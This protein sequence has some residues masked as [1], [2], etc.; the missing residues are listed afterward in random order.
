MTGHP[1][2]GPGEGHPVPRLQ[3][4]DDEALGV[5]AHGG[6]VHPPAGV[7]GH[8]GEAQAGGQR[9]GLAAPDAHLAGEDDGSLGLGGGGGEL[10]LPLGGGQGEGGLQGAQG[11]VEGAGDGALVCKLLGLGRG[12]LGGGGGGPAA[13]SCWFICLVILVLFCFNW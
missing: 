13:V 6:P 12:L 2:A 9:H 10:G 8:V 5:L 4:G 3:G 7:V 11:D 1:L